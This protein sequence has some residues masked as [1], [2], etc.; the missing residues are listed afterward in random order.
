MRI[1]FFKRAG[2]Y[3]LDAVPILLLLVSLQTWFVGD[4]IKQSIHPEFD[5]LE[6]MYYENLET[7]Q[8][9]MQPF[10]DQ[11]TEGEITYDEYIELAQPYQ[12]DFINNNIYLYDIVFVSYWLTSILYLVISFNV[13]Y[14]VYMILMKGNSLGRKLFQLELQGNVTW[15]NI[16][17]RE[18]LWKHL[19][20]LGTLSAGLAIDFGMIAFTKKKKALRD[21]YSKT[22]IAQQGVNYP[23]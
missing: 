15:Y 4:L 17:M 13:I 23:F 3:L 19:F 1:G 12:D 6:T 14:L 11:Y 10:Y 20:W 8:D 18:F 21:I 22:Y 5:R 2:S 16:I 7:Y 9:F